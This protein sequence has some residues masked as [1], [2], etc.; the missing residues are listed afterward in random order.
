MKK[1]VAVLFALT[2]IM[3]ACG[4]SSDGS[5][6]SNEPVQT[7]VSEQQEGAEEVTVESGDETVAEEET[8]VTSDTGIWK[9]AKASPA[10]KA[11]DLFICRFF[12]IEKQEQRI[13]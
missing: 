4:N 1:V 2:F 10:K 7:D 12:N 6:A 8:A 13:V 5:P 9:K 3:C 11:D